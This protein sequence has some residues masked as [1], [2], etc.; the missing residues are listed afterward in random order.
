[1]KDSQANT[2]A[3]QTTDK[4]NT[5]KTVDRAVSYV[6]KESNKNQRS[7]HLNERSK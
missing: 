6:M 7:K 5:S 4:Y 3:T 1:M 2:V